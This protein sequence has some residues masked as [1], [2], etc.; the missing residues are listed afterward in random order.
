MWHR[1]P[2]LNR[3]SNQLNCENWEAVNHQQRYERIDT[4]PHH[5]FPDGQSTRPTACGRIQFRRW[6]EHEEQN[7]DRL[8]F[9]ADQPDASIPQ[10]P[11]RERK[12]QRSRL[13]R[14]FPVAW[15]QPSV[16]QQRRNQLESQQPGNGFSKTNRLT[17]L[18]L[19]ISRNSWIRV[20]LR[21]LTEGNRLVINRTEFIYK[22]LGSS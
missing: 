8:H 11:R 6:S 21:T 12:G 5:Q 15:F 22:P 9:S 18:L 2:T 4:G 17:T 1:K 10:E 20:H 7:R 3:S 19:E 14:R 16:A 13:W